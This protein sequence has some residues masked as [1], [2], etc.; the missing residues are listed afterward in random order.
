MGFIGG[1]ELGGLYY[2]EAVRPIL[3]AEVPDLAHSAALIGP[4]S[5]VL[6]YDTERSTDHDWGPRLLLFLGEPDHEAY[7]AQ[8]SDALARRLPRSF[9]GHAT[10]FGLPDDGSVADGER[11]TRHRVAVCTVRGYFRTLLGVDPLGE[12]RPADW[13][14]LP[15]Q[16]LLEAT[17]GRVYRDGL[18]ALEPLRRKLAYYPRDVWLTRLAAQWIRI[19]QEQ[20][21]MGRAGEADDELGS[22]LIAARLVGDVM[23]LC[24]LMERRYAPYSKWFGTAFGRLDCAP[25]LA[26]SLESAL[27]A[28]SWRDR[29]EHLVRAYEAAGALHNRLGITRPV[30]A[31]VTSF[32]DRPYR[33]IDAGAF[34]AAI[35][36]RIEDPAVR[37]LSAPMGGADQLSDSTD[38]LSNPEAYAKLGALYG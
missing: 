30:D 16:K 12:L 10:D 36:E 18:G 21:F 4:G 6:G 35:D 13:L 24:F 22:A 11:P 2:A 27:R 3:D 9:R 17:A 32:Y 1:L 38:L 23:R 14:C 34:I 25:E 31:R 8:I 33:V 7:G 19:G 28:S 5:E 37:A 29:E 26:P 20:P 15:E